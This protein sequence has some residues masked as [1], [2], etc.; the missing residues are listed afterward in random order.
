MTS[1]VEDLESS[2]GLIEK[3][4]QTLTQQMER[5]IKQQEEAVRKVNSL[6]ISEGEDASGSRAKG[7]NR[8]DGHDSTRFLA[9]K[10]RKLKIPTFDGKDPDGW[11]LRAEC[12]FSLH[13]LSQEDQIDVSFI[14][15]EDDAVKWFQGGNKRHPITR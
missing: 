6:S 7:R 1:R 13:R 11:V 8:G 15:F 2:V 3:G 14:A 5:I 12:Y 10:G 4:L 9:V